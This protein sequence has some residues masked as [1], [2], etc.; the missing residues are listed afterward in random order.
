MTRGTG[1]GTAAL[2]LLAAALVALA[3]PGPALVPGAGGDEP[4]W[5]LGVFGDGLGLDGGGYLAALYA[6]F[7]AYLAVVWAAPRLGGRVVAGAVVAAVVLFAVAPPLLSLDV[8]SYISYGRLQVEGLNPYDF[9]PADIPL[10]PAAARVDD[11][12]EAVSVYGPLWSAVSYPLALLGPQAA[13]WAMKALAA[14]AALA[15]VAVA[16][17]L[18]A[19]RGLDPARTGALV[20]LNP[21]LLVHGVGGAHNDVLMTL[22]VVA[23]AWLLASDR[24]AGAGVAL[25]G[26]IAVKAAAGLAAPFAA[27]GAWRAGHPRAP[28]PSTVGLS[29]HGGHKPTLGGLGRLILGAAGAAVALAAFALAAYGGSAAEALDVLGGSQDKVSRY[30]VPATAARGLGVDV[31]PVRTVA[32]TLFVVAFAYLLWRTWRGMDWI[33]AAGWATLAL[34]LATA[35][36]TPWYVIWALPLAA[37]SRDRALLG[38]TL[39]LGGFQLVNSVPL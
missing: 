9:A 27:L 13:L 11:Y 20:G 30:S 2:A 35:Y 23:G 10:D 5:V 39:A 7:A 29:P 33:R 12:R 26:G 1:A 32:V 36:L 34:L 3:A 16:A 8:F 31:D 24:P 17:R 22:G 25:T 18:A 19:L 6:A 21:I 4:R 37:V 28:I 15:L 14:A 38:V